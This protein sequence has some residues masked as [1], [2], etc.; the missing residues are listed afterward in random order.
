LGSSNVKYLV[1]PKLGDWWVG[2]VS[3]VSGAKRGYAGV[4]ARPCIF[5][6]PPGRE[7][8]F[9]SLSVPGVTHNSI[10]DITS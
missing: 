5:P 8:R 2:I 6:E 9:E 3:G 10:P 1:D 4:P 7:N